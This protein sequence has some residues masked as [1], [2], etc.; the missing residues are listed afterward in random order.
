MANTT[1]SFTIAKVVSFIV[2]LPLFTKG[3]SFYAPKGATKKHGMKMIHYAGR[4]A[5]VASLLI[6]QG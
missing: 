2:L 3:E 5:E 6:R 4:D 1:A